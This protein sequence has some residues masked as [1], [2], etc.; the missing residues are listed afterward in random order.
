MDTVAAR[1]GKM[2]S[3]VQNAG[4]VVEVIDVEA[5]NKK[6]TRSLYK[7]RVP[8]HPKRVKGKFRQVKWVIMAL[9]LGVYYLLPWVRWDRGEGAPNQAVLV[10]FANERF[11]FFFIEIWPQEFYYITGL[12]ILAAVGL[13]LV[14]ALA[15]RVWCGYMCPQ[16]V[17]TEVFLWM[18][19][20]IEGDR[21]KQMKLDKAPWTGRKVAIKSLKHG[22]ETC[23]VK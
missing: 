9:T 12:L 8:I 14:T 4:D 15:G 2:P 18:E 10:D 21:P 19:R 7:K 1:D 13:F 5:V 6:E 23:T 16:T 22:V 11:F 17:W 3:P 20:R